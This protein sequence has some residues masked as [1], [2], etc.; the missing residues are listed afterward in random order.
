MVYVDLA[1][2]LF[3]LVPSDPECVM[4]EFLVVLIDIP[5]IF[6]SKN[7]LGVKFEIFINSVQMTLE[8]L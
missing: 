8:V 2:V 6:N 1:E 7:G 3:E 5:V 4:D